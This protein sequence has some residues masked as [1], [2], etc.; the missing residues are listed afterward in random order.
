MGVALCASSA[1]ARA[2]FAEA[3]SALG[4]SL[5]RRC[6]EGPIEA[7][8]QTEVA[9]PAL[10]THGV[11]CVAAARER[12]LL[13]DVSAVVGHSLGEWT[14]LVVAG[15]LSLA[16]AVRL[17]HL[18]GRWM[19]QAVAPGAGA[20]AAVLGADRDAVASACAE[21]RAAAPH[22]HVACATFNGEGHTV[23]SGHAGAVARAGERALAA[24]ALKV[25]PLTVSAP[26]HCELMRPV[27]APLA[28]ALASAAVS[29]PTLA[30]SSTIVDG[31]LDRPDAIRT[32]LVDQLVAPVAWNDALMRLVE[33]GRDR[34]LV[35]GSGRQL[36]R[37]VKRMR[38]GWD[39]SLLDDKALTA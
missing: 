4:W 20:M 33:S 13:D 19:Q 25:L 18:R 8:T 6:A 14:A 21:T 29:P 1:A 32:A 11:A 38:L 30:V 16:E 34:A 26:F 12:G 22:E 10:L 2:V 36:A 28:D 39:V 23:I 9:Q 7:L 27:E 31:W 35:V 24:G 5:S 17:V 3:D 37:M 15:A